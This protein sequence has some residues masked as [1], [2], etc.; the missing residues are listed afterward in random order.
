MNE[1]KWSVSELAT[2]AFTWVSLLIFCN[3]LL[4]FVKT[5]RASL[6]GESCR[7]STLSGAVIAGQMK[8][9]KKKPPTD[10]RALFGYDCDT[11]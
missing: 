4:T 10:I 3:I 2:A 5:E 6:E 8:R 11:R 7:M 9:R 1:L